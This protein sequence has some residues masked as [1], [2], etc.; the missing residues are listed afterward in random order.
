[1]SKLIISIISVF[2]S[3]QIATAAEDKIESAVSAAPD[4]LAKNATV[5][6]WDGTVLRQGTNTWTCLPDI[7]SCN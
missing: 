4:S 6:D 1:M 2:F 3:V 7:K 5:V